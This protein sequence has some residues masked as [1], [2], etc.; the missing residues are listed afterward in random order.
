MSTFSMRPKN[1]YAPKIRALKA[2]KLDGTLYR[3]RENVEAQIAEMLCLRQSQR[4]ARLPE[5]HPETIIHFIRRMR[6]SRKQ[7]YGLFVQELNRRIT[8]I[9]KW[10]TRE[11]DKV[12]RQDIAT[13]VE[14][15]I[16]TLVLSEKSS[17]KTEILE[18]AF[19]RVVEKRTL[20]IVRNYNRSPWSRKAAFPPQGDEFDDED[21]IEQ[22]VE[23]A[24]DDRDGPEV[25][26]IQNLENARKAQIVRAACAVVKDPL[27]LIVLKLHFE[28]GLPISSKDPDRPDVAG[29]VGESRG[30]V[31]Y[32]MSRALKQIRKALGGK[33]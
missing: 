15:G 18:V 7:V 27:D 24:A 2:R 22:P 26:A 11:L 9:T 12:T 4:A 16:L 28:D 29:K 14:I 31:N 33:Q 3:R 20:N 13:T 8:R 32:R 17:R 6:L 30:Q 5:M 19:A 21:E 1:G 23:L 25:L 10:H